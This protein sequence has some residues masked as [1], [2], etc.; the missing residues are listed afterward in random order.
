VQRPPGIHGTLRMVGGPPPG[1]NRAVAGTVTI[2]SSTGSHCNLPVVAGGSFEAT[3]PVGSYR[4]TGHSPLFG[5]GKY[6]CS[7]GAVRVTSAGESAVAV[8]CPV[9]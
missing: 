9:P 7:G 8:V 4:V 2:T 1:L 6:E 3:L 5:G